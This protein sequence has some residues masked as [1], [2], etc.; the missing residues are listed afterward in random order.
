MPDPVLTSW[1]PRQRSAA[2]A[3]RGVSLLL[4]GGRADDTRPVERQHASWWRMALLGR[5]LARATVPQ[6]VAVELLRY[7]ARGWNDGPGAE[8]G[9]VLDG[10]W[11][12]RAVRE[13]Y[14]DVPVVLVGH[15]MGGRGACALADADGVTGVVALA[16]WLTAGEPVRPARRQ[17]LVIAHGL[18]DR[19]TS[20]GGS[21]EWARRA[22]SVGARV[23]RYEMGAVGHFMLTD[24]GQW[25]GL[26]RDATLGLLGVAPLPAEMAQALQSPA[27]DA[28][29]R[30]NPTW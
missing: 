15:S 6:G 25:N 28:G 10:R 4:H 18:A 22:R 17:R 16:P 14:G 8:P 23:A 3:V 19:W 24:A 13:R 26:V 20:P 29:L 11:A 5:T 1:R 9:P 12:L 7:R 27:G 30:L 2:A 21:L